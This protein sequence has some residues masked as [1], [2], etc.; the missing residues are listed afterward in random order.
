[1]F[2]CSKTRFACNVFENNR[3]ILDESAGGDW[4]VFLVEYRGVRAARVD[5]ADGGSLSAFTRLV[6]LRIGSMRV[7]CRGLR[8]TVLRSSDQRGK[9]RNGSESAPKSSSGYELSL[10]IP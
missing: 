5:S 6:R 4:P 7:R 1:M 3:T 9:D 10:L 2:P 8:H